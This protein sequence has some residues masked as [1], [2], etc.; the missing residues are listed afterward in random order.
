MG[1]PAAISLIA[2]VWGNSRWMSQFDPGNIRASLQMEASVVVEA[3][4]ERAL[5][6]KNSRL[7]NI[8][9]YL[10]STS[11]E[12]FHVLTVESWRRHAHGLCN[13]PILIN[14]M[15]VR[16]YVPDMPE[17]YFRLPYPAAKADMLRYGLLYH[18]G[19]IYF[20]SDVLVVKDLDEV[21]QLAAEKGMVSY[22]DQKDSSKSCGESFASDFVGGQ[23]GSPFFKEVWRK[24]KAA[25]RKRCPKSDTSQET[26]CCYD[27][28]DAPCNIPWNQLGEGIAHSTGK[29]GI[30]T[31]CFVG[32]T[33]FTPSGFVDA[34]EKFNGDTSKAEEHMKSKGAAHV[35]ERTAY[36]TFKA[37]LQWP[38]SCKH[39]R[40]RSTL[41]GELFSRS[42][43]SSHGQRPPP[44]VATTSLFLKRHPEFAALIR[45]EG[46]VPC[47]SKGWHD[48]LSDDVPAVSLEVSKQQP[49]ET[50]AKNCK[51]FTLWEYKDAPLYARLNV[52]SWRRHTR[53]LCEEPILV[54]SKNV[55]KWIPDMPKEF[56]R[57]PYHAATSD[58]IRYGLLYHHG[59]IYMDA[60][61]IVLKDLTPVIQRLDDHD[62]ISYATNSNAGGVCSD[63]F[64]S[65]FIAGR[66]G[67]IFMKKMWDK[68]K[69]MIT[70]HCPL[71]DKTKEIVCCFDDPKVECHV[72]FAGIGEG[73]S[74]P[75]LNK[76][77]KDKV[78]MK[79]YC[80]A[81]EESFVPDHFAYV[82]EHVP[83]LQEAQSYMEK[84][85]IKKGL[86]RMAF[87]M[88]NS[89]IPL[90][91]YNCQK[92]FTKGTTA[93]HLYLTS[94]STGH[95][96]EPK[97]KS[98][99]TQ[100]FLAEHPD[101]A[102]FQQSHKGGWP[103]KSA[104]KAAPAVSD[105]AGAP[106]P[107]HPAPVAAAPAVP[108][109]DAGVMEVVNTGSTS[110]KIFTWWEYE[111]LGPLYL[112]I[113]VESWRRRA[114][115][116]SE[117]V[118]LTAA[119]VREHVPDVPEEFFRLPYPEARAD[120]I[121]W[122][123]IYHNG[124]VF[125][126]PD[127][128]MAGDISTILEKLDSYD[129]ISSQEDPAEEQCTDQFN[130]AIIAGPKGSPYLK[131][132]WEAHRTKMVK[133]CPLKDK[134][135]EIICCFD[136]VKE[137]CHV[138]WLS[139]NRGIAH[140]VLREWKKNGKLNSYCF[141]RGDAFQ[142][143]Q[144]G[145]VVRQ[146]WELDR[147]RKFWEK[148][149][150]E[151]PLERI[152][153]HFQQHGMQLQELDCAKLFNTSTAIGALY[154]GA[155]AA[156]ASKPLTRSDS[157]ETAKFYRDNPFMKSVNHEFQGGLPC[158]QT[159]P[160]ALPTL[161]PDFGG[162]KACRIFTLWEYPE[163]GV[164]VFKL[165][166]IE[167]WR[168]HTHGLCQEPILINDKNVKEWIPDM[169]DEYFR[170]PSPAPKS[171]LIRY[172]LLYH[173]GGLY[174]DADFVAVKD[175]DPIVAL[176]ETHDFISYQEKGEAGQA[177]SA[178]FSSN[179][180]GGRKGS[181]V[182]KYIWEQQKEKMQVRCVKGV[183]NQACCYDSKKVCNV[184]WASLGEGVSHPAYND[185][186]RTGDIFETFCF[187]DEWTFVPDH[188]AYSVEHIPSKDE[189]LKY[190]TERGIQKPLDR[191]VYHLFNA[192]TP[193]KTWKCMALLDPRRLMGYLYTESFKSENG[194]R[195]V[196]KSEESTAWLKAHPEFTK[197]QQVY[198][199]WQPC[200]GPVGTTP[201]PTAEIQEEADGGC[202]IF[203]LWEYK[204]GPPLSVA[205]NVEGWRR[206][207]GGRCAP[208]L[209]NDENV[210]T[211]LPD[212]PKEYFRMPY[213][214][215][216]SDIIRYGLLYHHGGI[217]MDTDFLV[218]K[219]L[220]EI[221]T[222]IR[223]F[224]LVSYVD[225]GG[226]SLEKGACSRHFSSNFMASRKGSSFMKAVWEKQKHHMVTHCPLSERELEKVCCFDSVNV[227]CHIPW[228]GIGEGV[229]H[230]VFD[231]LEGEGI[232]FKSFCFADDR[233]FTPPDMITLLDKSADFASRAWKQ[234]GK[235][236]S[237]DPW[238]RIMYHTFNSIMPWSGYSCRQIF[239]Q[240]SVYGKLNYLSYTTGKGALSL[241][242]TEEYIRWLK[243]Y[244]MKRLSDNSD[245]LPCS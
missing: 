239:N 17:E 109:K 142:P 224:D 210:L 130:P 106:A 228:A 71:S 214:Q 95:G 64:S 56:F 68:Q 151:R 85:G 177:C 134:E 76:M 49:S 41:L 237:R 40:D 222:L 11:V 79:T 107:A 98:K 198:N 81:D 67:S 236:T 138:P 111:G 232:H 5:A 108:A 39:F 104:H 188:F 155:F 24:Q 52:E 203:T 223:S 220:D 206:H 180:I 53:E 45:K 96:K 160:P 60:D 136:E 147:A 65:N 82:L 144:L 93:G 66:K 193:L 149:N 185:L 219:D 114:P 242:A 70:K 25:V 168:R 99:E 137:N 158:K 7:C 19:G 8:F 215:A 191:I 13:E 132:V 90:K 59:G 182:H 131:A 118:L 162:K 140:P 167:S 226:G 243:K 61:F 213:S 113:N 212:M 146:R 241:P 9:T 126:E 119:N 204:A 125:L 112:R 33:S 218:V 205:I 50:P 6:A 121:R 63:S 37:I 169:P 22:M 201:E 196:A 229:S 18:H 87:H 200:P 173:H 174:M 166:N 4:Q 92:L 14:D 103:C 58:L 216:K 46:Q 207:S 35:L 34:L 62:L 42:F 43:S 86:D 230:K 80:F 28:D 197:Y 31:H 38:S 171:D 221:L 186:L 189:A 238:G 199:G 21:I 170:M 233:G 83:D 27:N 235:A 54:N 211:Y 209:I 133:H 78:P 29:S 2:L 73:T 163:G 84:R 51:I 69:A 227:D 15:N 179:L 234:M 231:E 91:T 156:E 120:S 225:E 97:P 240:S 208:V 20:D 57:F 161:P 245:G 139:M 181:L 157:K 190:M 154:A 123:A 143:N 77:L 48:A 183:T 23:K 172:A 124:G 88:F 3:T 116:C 128:L 187:A 102:E 110:C 202:K 159:G 94:F 192:I 129:L 74:H 55:M 153:Y 16:I 127:V 115:Q 117:P 176:L 47:W 44:A 194:R 217:Y 122:G 165:L 141:Y 195:P 178:A 10:D 152:L 75:M 72:P 175:M 101:F 148:R 145:E 164:P 150:V 105:F 12:L 184:P 26:L 100:A 89:I 244:K 135:K 32:D 36:H 1:L 30:S